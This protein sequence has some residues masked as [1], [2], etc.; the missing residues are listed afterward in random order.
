MKQLTAV[1][2]NSYVKEP[3]REIWLQFLEN[4]FGFLPYYDEQSKFPFAF[5]FGLSPVKMKL[6]N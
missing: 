2:L 4:F 3:R 6:P 5:G 1:K